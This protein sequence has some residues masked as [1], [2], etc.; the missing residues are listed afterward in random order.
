MEI[1]LNSLNTKYNHIDCSEV[2]NQIAI[3]FKN[4]RSYEWSWVRDFIEMVISKNTLDTRLRILDIGCGGGRN[5][6]SYTNDKIEM[7]GL[8]NST[9]FIRL[10]REDNLPVLW[11]DMT[12]I[13]CE[14]EEFD[15]LL[16]VASFHHLSTLDSRL[17]C[18][19]EMNRILKIGG[20]MLLSVWSIN[21]PSKTKR[22]FNNYGHTL[23]PWKRLDGKIFNRYYYI[24][25]V[26]ELINILKQSGFIVILSNWSCGNEVFTLQKIANISN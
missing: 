17:K 16:S 20:F 24:F 22:K 7:I 19:K 26:E 6:K 4:S 3:E 21:Q 13:P 1:S 9:E 25:K 11:G 14:D 10:C 2:Y 12:N 8:D 15:H 5:I 18:L 23:V